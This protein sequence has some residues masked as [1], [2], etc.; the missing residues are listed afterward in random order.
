[1]ILAGQMR[2]SVK[3]AIKQFVRRCT[4]CTNAHVGKKSEARS[5]KNKGNG[6]NE[7]EQQKGM[8]VAKRNHAASCE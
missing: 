8:V 4:G 3:V 5:Q 6:S 2:R 7:Q 1:M